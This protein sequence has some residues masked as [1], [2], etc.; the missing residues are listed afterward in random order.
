MRSI[1]I[2]ALSPF[3]GEKMHNIIKKESTS[4]ASVDQYSGIT[5]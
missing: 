5:L 4:L 3:N 2:T 1:P